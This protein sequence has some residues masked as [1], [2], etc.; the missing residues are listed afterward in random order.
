LIKRL[1]K[2][3]GSET[4]KPANEEE[5]QVGTKQ[6]ENSA[7]AGDQKT[8]EEIS[9]K[10]KQAKSD[11]QSEEDD[12]SVNSKD[13]IEVKHAPKQR[14]EPTIEK[15][16]D[17]SLVEIEREKV[18]TAVNDEPLPPIEI[19][20]EKV[21]IAIHDEPMIEDEQ[22]RKQWKIQQYDQSLQFLTQ[23]TLN[24][25][26]AKRI[27]QYLV[28]VPEDLGFFNN[29]VKMMSARGKRKYEIEVTKVF[30][31]HGFHQHADEFVSN[32]QI[33]MH[34][35]NKQNMFNLMLN[36]FD[37][38]NGC[39]SIKSFFGR[40]FLFTDCSTKAFNFASRP[41]V[42]RFE[43]KADTGE[44]QPEV[45]QEEFILV[46]D[47]AL[48]RRMNSSKSDKKQMASFYDSRS[49]MPN[50][51]AKQTITIEIP[52]T[53]DAPRGVTSLPYNGFESDVELMEYQQDTTTEYLESYV[54]TPDQI[55]MLWLLAVKRI[56]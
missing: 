18:P 43:R 25:T 36:G 27:A 12:D 37:E 44:I 28:Q 15:Q 8:V 47:V 13:S 32:H 49:T 55:S 26:E 53:K 29:Y 42:Y 40:G 30:R 20:R 24:F 23:Y 16:H 6:N 31:I 7:P 35:V 45:D 33:L 19:E 17:E 9:S 56:D 1:L 11:E 5:I 52:F 14:E 39:S 3:M 38:Q 4:S 21:R 48:G 41:D 54:Y 34:G 51:V 46:C 10:L 2:A 50:N 22:A